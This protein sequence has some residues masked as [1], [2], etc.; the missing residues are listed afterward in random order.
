MDGENDEDGEHDEDEEKDEDNEKTE[1]GGKDTEGEKDAQCA[2][3][4]L[5]PV[6]SSVP[7]P[8]S[9]LLNLR[10]MGGPPPH[11]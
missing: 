6:G 1:D 4:N 5:G 2:R 7:G 3:S 11:P 10:E 9:S 8:L